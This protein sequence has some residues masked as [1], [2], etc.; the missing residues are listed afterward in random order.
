VTSSFPNI[1]YSLFINGLVKLTDKMSDPDESF[2]ILRDIKPYTVEPLAKNVTDNINCEELAGASAYVDPDQP[3]VP[4]TPGPVHKKNK[5]VFVC[6]REPGGCIGL[7]QM[8]SILVHTWM[9][10][11]RCVF[12]AIV[13]IKF[14]RVVVVSGQVLTALT[15]RI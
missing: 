8:W 14:R 4:P 10:R 11:H 7:F 2:D 9:C 1:R 3:P 13:F 15:P 5:V 6:I 12:L